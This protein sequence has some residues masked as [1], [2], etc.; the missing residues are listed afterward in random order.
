MDR[1]LNTIVE[2]IISKSWNSLSMSMALGIGMEQ[3]RQCLREVNIKKKGWLKLLFLLLE[4]FDIKGV[5]HDCFVLSYVDYE[6]MW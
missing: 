2:R 5:E 3:F 1:I 6:I 4:F